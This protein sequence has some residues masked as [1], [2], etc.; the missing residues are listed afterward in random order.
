M[1]SGPVDIVVAHEGLP[2]TPLVSNYRSFIPP[3]IV[4][5]ADRVRAQMGEIADRL[6]PELWVHGHW[7][8]RMSAVRGTTRVECLNE[9]RGPFEETV[10][11]CRLDTLETLPVTL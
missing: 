3:E 11:A 8:H 5:V 4:E 6:E 7:H 2:G 1:S 10:L 9:S